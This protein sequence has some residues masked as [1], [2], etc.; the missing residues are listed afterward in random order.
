ALALAY[1]G[2][3]ARSAR[4]A[5]PEPGWS[6]SLEVDQRHKLRRRGPGCEQNPLVLDDSHGGSAHI[7]EFK[8]QHF[9]TLESV[10]ILTAAKAGLTILAPGA[11]CEAEGSDDITNQRLSAAIT[12]AKHISARQLV[13][14]T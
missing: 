8:F 14:V 3:I 4:W 7:C 9:C 13:P 6:F 12:Q 11:L 5:I 2:N 1:A 10:K